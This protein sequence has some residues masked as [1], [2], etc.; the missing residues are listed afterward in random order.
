M[1]LFVPVIEWLERLLLAYWSLTGDAEFSKMLRIFLLL[2]K[3][4]DLKYNLEVELHV[5]CIFSSL[6]DTRSF[7]IVVLNLQY[8]QQCIRVLV[9]LHFPPWYVLKVMIGVVNTIKLY[10]SSYLSFA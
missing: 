10:I 2:L 7:S 4:T 5:M 1:F 6:A 8:F 3:D 9:T